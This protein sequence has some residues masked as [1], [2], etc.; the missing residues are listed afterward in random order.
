M[1]PLLLWEKG[2][3]INAVSEEDLF[4]YPLQF[5]FGGLQIKLPKRQ[6]NKKDIF[7]HIFTGEFTE[8]YDSGRENLSLY[9]ILKREGGGEKDALGKQMT[10]RT[11]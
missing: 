6:I 5:I 1:M 11:R 3:K 4:L 2:G 9:T 7:I 10:F 8:K